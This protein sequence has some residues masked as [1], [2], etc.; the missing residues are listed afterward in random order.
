[1]V[2]WAAAVRD[3]KLEDFTFHDRGDPKGTT[4][5]QSVLPKLKETAKENP[6]L[7]KRTS[8]RQKCD[9]NN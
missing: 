3:A 5:T 2:A 9:L 8:E 1:M 6:E 4:T 7:L